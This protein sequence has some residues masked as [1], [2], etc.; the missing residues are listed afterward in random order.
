MLENKFN[1]FNSLFKVV[2]SLNFTHLLKKNK[3]S[4]AA[5]KNCALNASW[6]EFALSDADLSWFL[7]VLSC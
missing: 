6:S 4:L 1:Y 3:K 2:A 5:L 7:S